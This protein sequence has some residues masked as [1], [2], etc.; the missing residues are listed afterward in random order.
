MAVNLPKSMQFVEYKPSMVGIPTQSVA[1][2]YDRLD[3][4][5]LRTEAESNK[6][7]ETLAN[8]TAIA[9]EGDK[10]YLNDLLGKVE[11]IVEQA[12]T[13]KNLPGYAKQIRKLVGDINASPEYATVRNNG[14]LA[15]EYRKINL[16]LSSKYGTENIVQS[17]D[18]PN[19][20]SSFGPNG[21]L[22]QFQGFAT[23]RPDYLKGMDDV[24][25]KNV[26]I[27]GSQ[28]AMEKF[29]DD[30]LALSNYRETPE[31]RVHI[32]EISQQMTGMPFDRLPAV[33]NEQG[34]YVV[35]P[36]GVAVME[37]MNDLLK[38]AGA[39]YIKTKAVKSAMDS[40]G[41][42]ENLKNKGIISSGIANVSLTDGT[43]AADQTIAVFDDRV[44]NTE[45]DDQL[46]SLVASDP[47]VS[48]Y[49]N[50]SGGKDG[51]E[52]GAGIQSNQ[53]IGSKLTSG[54]GP[55]GYP[56]IQVEYN[57]KVA[58]KGIERGI[59][60]YEVSPEDAPFI[61][62]SMKGTLMQLRSSST[63]QANRM[64]MVPAIA[65]IF[66]PGLNSWMRGESDTAHRFVSPNGTG[67]SLDIKKVASGYAV[68]DSEGN[69]LTKNGKPFIATS[70][71]TLRN[72]IGT[73]IVNQF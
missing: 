38:D 28:G 27:V 66:D 26:D 23:Q 42:Y 44:K 33:Q 69:P 41:Q 29:V 54:V 53:I 70:E 57:N 65:N 45:L 59:G 20:F 21:E 32:N 46:V 56:L 43:D 55:N 16:D 6:I 22:R 40:G 24:Y 15:E 50:A 64:S 72:F 14:R 3:R 10:P 12:S 17:G 5:A 51:F 73:S 18:N 52:R 11:G 7:R 1:R 37:K 35:G 39:R 48:L 71:N 36:E 67:Q 68:Y 4:E 47:T 58:G 9:S 34:E 25:M 8:H 61:Q 60:Y 2:Y 49:A 31:G 63:T 19:N 13:E 30:G 62:Q